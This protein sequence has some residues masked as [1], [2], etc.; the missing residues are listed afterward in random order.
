MTGLEAELDLVSIDKVDV[1]NELRRFTLLWVLE[2]DFQKFGPY[3]KPKVCLLTMLSGFWCPAR[4]CHAPVTHLW[5]RHPAV[6]D[7]TQTMGIDVSQH[8]ESIF[9]GPSS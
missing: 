7:M 3:C 2:V 8:A 5:L 4:P 1:R 9:E 6:S